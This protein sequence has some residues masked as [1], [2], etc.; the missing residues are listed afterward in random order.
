MFTTTN[1]PTPASP[2]SAPQFVAWVRE[3]VAKIVAVLSPYT[4]ETPNPEAA[5]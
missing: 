4:V 3:R 5:A 2:Q 1:S